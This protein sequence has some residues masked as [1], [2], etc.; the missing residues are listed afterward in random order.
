[1]NTARPAQGPTRSRAV[2]LIFSLALLAAGAGFL[3]LGTWQVQRL[4]WKQDLIARVDAR[5]VAS[6]VAP[7]MPQRWGAINRADDEYRRVRVQGHFLSDTDIRVQATTRLGPG[8]WLLAPLQTDAGVVWINRGF[9]PQDLAAEDIAALDPQAEVSI[10]GLLRLNEPGGAFLRE[11]QPGQQRWYSRDVAAMS[12]ALGLD[13]A[14]PFFIDQQ[15]QGDGWPRGGLTVIQ[16]PDNHRVYALTWFALA[17]M[18]ALALAALWHP[19]WPSA[20]RRQLAR[21]TARDRHAQPSPGKHRP[22]RP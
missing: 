10:I 5:V 9:V 22:P 18:C 11:N 8:F 15:A 2:R 21:V 14:A 12:T 1:M 13:N 19:Q 3:W 7:P 20:L 17:L 16:F 4:A 6:P